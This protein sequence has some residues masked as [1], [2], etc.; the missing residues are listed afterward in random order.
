MNSFKK[1][2]TRRLSSITFLSFLSCLVN[3]ETF[4]DTYIPSICLKKNSEKSQIS[5]N[6]VP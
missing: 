6:V 4:Y 5:K 3:F 1:K 2:Q